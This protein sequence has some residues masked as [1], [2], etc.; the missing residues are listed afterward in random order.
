MVENNPQQWDEETQKPSYLQAMLSSSLNIYAGLGAAALGAGLSIPFGFRFAW[1]PL[2]CYAA[3][4]AIAALFIPNSAS[5]RHSVDLKHRR[6]RRAGIRQH[7]LS[8]L[9]DRLLSNTSE[10]S[11]YHRMLDRIHSLRTIAANRDSSITAADVENLEDS[12]VDFLGLLLARVLLEERQATMNAESLPHR[13]ETIQIQ[14]QSA[15]STEE[16]ATL[17]KALADLE[18]L[19]ERH[20]RL[21]N[22]QLAIDAAMLSMP[23][24]VEEIYHHMITNPNSSTAA[25]YLQRSVERLRVER[26]LDY[27]LSSEFEDIPVLRQVVN[28]I[29]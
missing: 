25:S 7:L 20:H 1:I 10:L 6:K 17:H 2:V 28:T 9:D 4:A 11:V 18:T 26:E 27:S 21:E 15:K 13:R 14:L 19:M 8:E 5:F 22:R 16:R 24:T 3:A 23:D 29:E 12:T